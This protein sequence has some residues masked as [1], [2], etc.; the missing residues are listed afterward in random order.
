M[1]QPITS[2]VHIDAALSKIAIGYSNEAYIADKIFP[3][4]Q[5]EKLTDYY[6]T[7][8][9]GDW[10]RNVVQRRE[11]G[12]VYQEGGLT[13]SPSQYS[14]VQ[15]A[16][17]FPIADETIT[18]ADAAID[19]EKAAADWLADQ[20]MLNRE[21]ILAS[22]IFDATAWANSTTLTG[23]NQWSDYENSDPVSDIKTA[24]QTVQQ[25]IGRLPN[26]LIMGVEVWDTLIQH[27]SLLERFKYTQKAILNKGEISTL[28]DIPN[29]LVG[30]AVKNTADEGQDMSG[31]YVWPKNALLAYITPRPGLRVPSAGY[32]FIWDQN[33]FTIPIKRVRDDQRDRDVLQGKCA[34]DQRVT[35]TDCAYEIIDAVA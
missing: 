8:T 20:F 22:K 30:A 14:C 1:A 17:A 11:P 35:A 33:G 7:W 25:S 21:I 28:F 4:V 2:S 3:L 19:L 27:P 5:V 9:K 31:S 6:Y 12:G 13:V 29:I 16:L 23:T 34:F 15:Y 18:N 24:K 26:T 10:F 32:T